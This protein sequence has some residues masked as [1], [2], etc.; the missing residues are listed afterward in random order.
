VEEPLVKKTVIDE[1]FVHSLTDIDTQDTAIHTPTAINPNLTL[2]IPQKMEGITENYQT[3][4]TL[5][6]SKPNS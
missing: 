4:E 6:V 3:N 2:T 5:S 1:S